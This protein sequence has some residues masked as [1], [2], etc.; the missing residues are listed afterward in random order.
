MKEIR[1]YQTRLELSIEQAA[2]LEAYAALYGKVERSLFPG[3]PLANRLAWS[4]REFLGGLGITARQFNA[5]AAGVRGKIASVREVRDRLLHLNH[6][7]MTFSFTT[8][9]PV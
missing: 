9:S 5:L 1:T 6:F 8:T 3:S 7:R 4:R 2:L